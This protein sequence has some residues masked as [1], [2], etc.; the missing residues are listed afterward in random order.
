MIEKTITTQ[1]RR[2]KALMT[3][4]AASLLL[5]ASA[6]TMAV[7]APTPPPKAP[8]AEETTGAL[9][10]PKLIDR[11]IAIVDDDVILSSEFQ[12]RYQ[13]VKANIAKA[14][15]GLPDEQ[16][17]QREV[18]DQLVVESIQLQMARRVGVRIS[19]QQLNQT[20]ASM[21]RQNGLTPL[22]L[23]AQIEQDGANYASFREKIRQEM[24]IQRVQ[25]GNVNRRIQISDQEIDSFLDSEEGRQLTA[26]DYRVM[27]AL[28]PVAEDAAKA[29]T[30]KAREYAQ[31]LYTKIS[32]GGDFKTLTADNSIFAISSGDLG[33]RKL[34]DLPSLIADLIPQLNAGEI[35]EPVRSASGFHLIQLAEKRGDGQ[36]AAQT[37][38][39]HILLKTSA[40]RDEAATKQALEALRQR[41]IDGEDFAQLAKEHSE[42]I[43][44][45]SEGGDLSWTSPG[46][47]VQAFQDTMDNTEINAISPIFKSPYG[48]H[49][50]EVLGR[51]DKDITS[52]I[53]RR[54]AG[55]FLHQ[56][57]FKDELEIWLQSIRDEAY[58]DYK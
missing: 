47:L 5:F 44:T 57:K 22:Q 4:A 28:I 14:G 35:A 58:I 38:A 51:R 36:I 3:S 8:I 56:R 43:G 33:W 12:T 39:R 1:P 21:A 30:L 55:K 15:R 52:D 32:K 20:I 49:I 11:V 31:Q 45:A 37:H 27:H 34:G 16:L 50:I 17:L 42:D 9:P 41:I 53:H 23:K 46:Q 18:L 29:Q 24:I 48:W 26:A 40:I 25:S 7:E 54:M 2:L 19:D 13:L 6:S 10:E